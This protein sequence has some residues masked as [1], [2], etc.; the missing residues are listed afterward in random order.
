MHCPI[1]RPVIKCHSG[2]IDFSTLHVHFASVTK[3]LQ[4]SSLSNIELIGKSQMVI[5]SKYS[6]VLDDWLN[7]DDDGSEIKFLLSNDSLCSMRVHLTKQKLCQLDQKILSDLF[8]IHAYIS[9]S[10][11]LITVISGTI[12]IFVL[13]HF[14]WNGCAYSN[15]LIF[16]YG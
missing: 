7:D 9:S 3:F 6:C 2:F 10:A 4:L 12:Y 5:I 16:I 8:A 13:K 15:C 1:S 14:I 11:K